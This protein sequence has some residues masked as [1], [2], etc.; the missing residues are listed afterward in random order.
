MIKILQLGNDDW[1]KRY[2]IP[3]DY[4][5]HFNDFP[6]KNPSSKKVK[7]KKKRKG[8]DVVLVTNGAKLDTAYWEE[9]TWMVD[10]YHV[11][12]MPGV[13]K[14]LSKAGDKFLKC[15]AA[16][17]M[18]ED[19][20][21]VIDH[22]EARYFFGQSGARMFPTNIFLNDNKISEYEVLDSC[23][24]R[25]K[26]NTHDQWVNIGAYRNSLYIDPKRLIKLWLTYRQH[27]VQVRLRVFIQPAGTDGNPDDNKVLTIDSNSEKELY[28]PIEASDQA[29]FAC[30]TIEV[31]GDG[32][33]T[34]GLLHSRWGREGRGEF[35]A[36]GKRIINMEKR[37]D[38]AYFFSPG[39]LKPPLTVYFSGARISAG[40]EAFPLFRKLKTP[41][42]LFTDVRLSLGEFYTDDDDT[43]E[44]KIIE[45]I[46]ET[47]KKLGFTKRQ[48]IMNGTSMG[49]YSSLLY[50]GK[51]GAY[52]INV[53][54][55]LANLGY[56]AQRGRLQRPD[57]FEA[58]YDID[59]QLVTKFD[60][61]HLHELDERFWKKFDKLDLSNTRLFVGYMND[62]DFDNKT[63]GRLKKSP[64]TKNA[65]QFTYKGFPGRHNDN[66]TIVLWFIDR[67]NQILQSDFDRKY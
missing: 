49:S 38:I 44:K 32:D 60:D 17:K 7:S 28:L 25:I 45:V 15:N 53:T 18:M 57:D 46:E 1:S 12:Y 37:E 41:T 16:E 9:L 5:W 65:L 64:A 11:I 51:I 26:V 27:N 21:V 54:K 34:L 31:K 22:L 39:D 20:Q 48:L 55:P 10:P 52:M 61:E 59:N 3:A 33:L 23:N 63:I 19:P 6:E 47:L 42:L 66:R 14:T 30:V 24:I 62:D 50:G 40:F 8:Y 2:K 13:D 56:I 4:H 35:I 58:I 67:L 29:R 43:M 36:G